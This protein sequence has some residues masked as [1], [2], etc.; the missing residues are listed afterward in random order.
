MPREELKKARQKAG[1]TQKEVAEQ[2]K[3]SERYYQHIEAGNRTGDFTIWDRLEDL[4]NIHQRKLREISENR[5]GK[6]AHQEKHQV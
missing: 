3:I 4:F 2:I 6:E 5:H 1:L